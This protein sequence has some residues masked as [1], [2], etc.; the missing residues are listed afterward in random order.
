MN[1]L[2][3]FTIVSDLD[4]RRPSQHLLAASDFLSGQ[5]LGPPSRLRLNCNV[6]WFSLRGDLA[7]TCVLYLFDIFVRLV[8]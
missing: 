8:R 2:V 3:T 1:S 7:L 4:V 6:R 5:I